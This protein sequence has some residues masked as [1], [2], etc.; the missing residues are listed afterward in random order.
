MQ[1]VDSVTDKFTGGLSEGLHVLKVEFEKL[2]AGHNQT[3]YNMKNQ[4]LRHL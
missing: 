3:W 4:L 2:V 1:R